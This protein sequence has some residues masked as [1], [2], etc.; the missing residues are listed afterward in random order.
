MPIQRSSLQSSP[1]L[2]RLPSKPLPWSAP[3]PGP[4]PLQ[5]GWAPSPP[6]VWS[7]SG[8]GN[9]AVTVAVL[10]TGVD[11]D[12]PDL[13]GK[14]IKGA[15]Y[16]DRDFD[17]KDLHGHGTHVAGIVAAQMNNAEGVTGLAPQVRILAVRVLDANGS[18]SLFN[19]APVL[20]THLPLP[21]T[22][23]WSFSGVDA[24]FKTISPTGRIR[25]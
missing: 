1:A 21:T 7:A 20:Y 14:V 16:V 24:V 17:P 2:G 25:L 8:T 19:I 22:I 5:P 15:D 10:D 12:H 18:G 13:R 11:Y 6:R 23:E 9:A 4:L 3:A